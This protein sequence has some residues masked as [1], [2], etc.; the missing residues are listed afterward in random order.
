MV[1]AN[2]FRKLKAGGC[3]VLHVQMTEDGWRTEQEWKDDRSLKGRVKM[4]FGLN[5]FARAEDEHL[6]IVESEGFRDIEIKP[7]AEMVTDEFDDVC[8][9]H[10]LTARKSD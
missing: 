1:I 3:M 7:I 5:C 9:Q 2:C 10:L 6:D 8:R 4:R